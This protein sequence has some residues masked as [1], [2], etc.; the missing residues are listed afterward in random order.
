MQKRRN[1]RSQDKAAQNWLSLW[2]PL[3]FQLSSHWKSTVTRHFQD[4]DNVPHAHR[5][6]K[7]NRM[8]ILEQLS[9]SNISPVRRAFPLQQGHVLQF[10]VHVVDANVKQIAHA[11]RN[12]QCHHY[13]QGKAGT[14]IFIEIS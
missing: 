10:D 12:Q 11:F 8:L 7:I 1:G 13:R 6:A 3:L 4:P 14:D 2:R 9:K 5:S